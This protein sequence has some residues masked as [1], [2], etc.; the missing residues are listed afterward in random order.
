MR[1]KMYA[2]RG[3]LPYNL[4]LKATLISSY[5]TI[6]KQSIYYYVYMWWILSCKLICDN[7]RKSNFVV[8]PTNTLSWSWAQ[9]M[10]RAKR[11]NS[12][13]CARL[14]ANLCWIWARNTTLSVWDNSCIS[15]RTS[16]HLCWKWA[17]N[18]TRQ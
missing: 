2:W 17:R 6:M 15:A 16:P 8:R 1:P 12:C 9:N 3:Q 10:T 4:L 13:Q 5:F 14:I 18:F 11:G 7:R